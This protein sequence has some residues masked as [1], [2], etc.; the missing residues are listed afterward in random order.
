MF[1]PKLC[2]VLIELTTLNSRIFISCS[3]E[4]NKIYG[5]KKGRNIYLEVW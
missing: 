4:H 3:A 1:S 5:C 2:T